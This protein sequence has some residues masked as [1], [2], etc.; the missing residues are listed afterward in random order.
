MPAMQIMQSYLDELSTAVLVGDWDT[1]R[2]HV[3]MP[4]TLITETATLVVDTEENLRA[5]FDNFHNMLKFQ[6]VT[7]YIRLVD[8]AV[9]LGDMLISGRYTSHV[10]AGA[11]RIIPP[12]RSNMTLRLNGNRWSAAAI[13]SSI[14]NMQWPIQMPRVDDALKGHHEG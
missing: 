7:H 3:A 5:G 9:E 1:Y 11:H 2:S 14:S 12:F 6:K 13:T 4:F 10:M 8:T